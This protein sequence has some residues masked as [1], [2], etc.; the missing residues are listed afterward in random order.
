MNIVIVRLENT[1]ANYNGLASQFAPGLPFFERQCPDVMHADAHG[2]MQATLKLLDAHLNEHHF[3]NSGES[4]TWWLQMTEGIRAFCRQNDLPLLPLVTSVDGLCRYYI[5]IFFLSIA[6]L[7]MQTQRGSSNYT[8]ENK[9][10][11]PIYSLSSLVRLKPNNLDANIWRMWL[12]RVEHT[13]LCMRHEITEAEVTQLHEIGKELR[14]R[15]LCESESHITINMHMETHYSVGI[16]RFGVLRETA[17]FGMENMLG[18]LKKDVQRNSNG[19]SVCQKVRLD[20]LL[21]TTSR[22]KLDRQPLPIK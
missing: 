13:A 9:A 15:I 18:Y 11:F 6:H 22:L 19:Q 12:L 4:K 1:L 10:N 2:N 3:R 5:I 14:Q 21:R 17:V 20:F 8:L 7:N 16:R